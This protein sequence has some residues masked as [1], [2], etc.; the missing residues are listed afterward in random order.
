MSSRISRFLS[1]TVG[2]PTS[3]LGRR[4]P[5]ALPDEE[6]GPSTSLFKWFGLNG[7]NR[8]PNLDRTLSTAEDEKAPRDKAKKLGTFSGVDPTINSR[9]PGSIPAYQRFSGVRA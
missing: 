6:H 4:T 9:S 2:D 7:F 3:Q 1:R 5:I 8:S